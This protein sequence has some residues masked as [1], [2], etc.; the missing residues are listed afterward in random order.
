MSLQTLETLS[1][2]VPALLGRGAD[3]PRGPVPSAVK[4]KG[5]PVS[6]DGSLGSS[7]SAGQRPRDEEAAG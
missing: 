3:S 1:L 7:S 6:P 5:G 2:E 4:L